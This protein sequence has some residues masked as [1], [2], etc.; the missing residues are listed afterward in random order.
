MIQLQIR[1]TQKE[2]E[3]IKKSSEIRNP[4]F[5]EFGRRAALNRKAEV[6]TENKI[7]LEIRALT[8]RMHETHREL[9][10][11][12]LE[13]FKDDFRSLLPEAT[14]AMKRISK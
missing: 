11:R 14:E 12:N 7:V 3:E 2:S 1:L 9:V 13:P 4:D 8:H 5:T 6:R 10:S